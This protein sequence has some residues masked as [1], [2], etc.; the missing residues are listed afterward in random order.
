MEKN[1]W[2]INGNETLPNSIELYTGIKRNMYLNGVFYFSNRRELT[3]AYYQ[4]ESR[5]ELDFNRNFNSSFIEINN[6]TNDNYDFFLDYQFNIPQ[7]LLYISFLKQG[8]DGLLSDRI[9]PGKINNDLETFFLNG[10]FV[11]NKDIIDINQYYAC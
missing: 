6:I 1:D 7:Y 5:T 2:I 8:S 10:S 3:W 4:R 9:Y 11:N